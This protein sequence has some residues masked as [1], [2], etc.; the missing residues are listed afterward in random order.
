[1]AVTPSKAS[2]CCAASVGTPQHH[3]VPLQAV[4]P[5]CPPGTALPGC[6]G[7]LPGTLLRSSTDPAQLPTLALG[8]GPVFAEQQNL[9][10]S[11]CLFAPC[12]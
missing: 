6:G 5:L 7:Q 8:L 1:M 9:G 2:P 11:N 4:W 3:P 10:G 12:N